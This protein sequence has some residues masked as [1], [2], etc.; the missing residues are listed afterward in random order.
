VLIAADRKGHIR[1]KIAEAELV[2]ADLDVMRPVREP[3]EAPHTKA[4]AQVAPRHCMPQARIVMSRVMTK[5]WTLS[6][7]NNMVSG[8]TS[9]A[10]PAVLNN[11][12]PAS[13]PLPPACMLTQ[14]VINA[15][16]ASVKVQFTVIVTDRGFKVRK[17]D[18]Q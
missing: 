17:Y 14:E 13:K 4:V 12:V 7:L 2:V 3:A 15:I 6:R 10:P 11:P 8:T 5:E 1:K 18:D 16:E 9:P